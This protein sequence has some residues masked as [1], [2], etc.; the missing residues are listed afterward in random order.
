M[1]QTSAPVEGLISYIQSLTRWSGSADIR[2][3][4]VA[5]SRREWLPR[6]GIA[7]AVGVCDSGFSEIIAGELESY[8]LP[9][10]L[11]YNRRELLEAMRQDKKNSGG[12]IGFSLP[13]GR[14]DWKFC[15]ITAQ[16]LDGLL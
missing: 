2:S 13:D 7:A 9:S 1:R 15:L 16:N 14:G 11:P 8:G 10:E 6:R 12:R 4:M 5:R 3:R